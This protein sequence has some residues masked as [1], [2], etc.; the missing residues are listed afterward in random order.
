[1]GGNNMKVLFLV[2][3]FWALIFANSY[4]TLSPERKIMVYPMGRPYPKTHQFFLENDI[5][6]YT[7][8]VCGG[9]EVSVC[10]VFVPRSEDASLSGYFILQQYRN[11]AVY[12]ITDTVTDAKQTCILEGDFD[13]KTFDASKNFN[14]RSAFFYHDAGGM[15]YITRHENT[16]HVHDERWNYCYA[17]KHIDDVWVRVASMVHTP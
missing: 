2:G 15:W 13:G 7:Y 6:K 5:K 3:S 14:H 9:R 17:D 12:F 10:E 1:M 11:G 16:L 4:Q 8:D